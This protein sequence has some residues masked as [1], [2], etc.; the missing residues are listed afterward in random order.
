MERVA[1]YCRLS[2]EDE[3]QGE[4]E[5]I[6][7]QKSMLLS[8]ALKQE[9]EVVGVY[10][11]DDFSG[12]DLSRPKWREMLLECEQGNVDIVLC[13]TQSRFSRD[14]SVV[15]QYIHG[16]FLEWRVRFVSIVDNAD[17]SNKGNKKARQIMALTNEWYVEEISDNI[18]A[19]FKDKMIKGEYIAAFAP[20]GYT[21]DPQQKNHLIV[22]EETAPIVRQI[23]AWHTSG[24]GAQTIARL[25]NEQHIPNPRKYQELTGKRKEKLYAEDEIGL[26]N[27]Y[28][29]RD[30]LHNQTYCGDTV[31]HTVEKVSYKSHKIRKLPKSEWIIAENT[32]APIIDRQIYEMSQRIFAMHKQTDK[33]GEIHLLSGKC[34]CYHCGALMQRNNSR[35]TNEY[36]RCRHKYDLPKERRCQTPNIPLP[37]LVEYVKAR[38]REMT[39]AYAESK[40]FCQTAKDNTFAKKQLSKAKT[41]YADIQKAVTTLYLDKVKGLIDEEQFTA[42]NTEFQ[43]RR[44]SLAKTIADYESELHTADELTARNLNAKQ[45]IECFMTDKKITRQLIMDLIDK[46]I[47]GEKDAYTGEIYI[48]IQWNF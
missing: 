41:E 19:V 36:L 44:D 4:S 1:I 40:T 33:T 17:S 43:H 21:K 46:I 24:K 15:E 29:V 9:W 23:F 35:D 38:I 20:Y 12:T 25:L 5:S 16:K 26:W 45:A 47:I 11:D 6:Q 10:A 7:N 18:R 3:T 48:D 31:Q 28:T 27:N 2:K 8:Y 14:M 39:K 37:Y 22:D 34:F 13:K 42:M 32:H 30:I